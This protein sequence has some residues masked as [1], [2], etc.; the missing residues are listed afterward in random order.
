MSMNN[1]TPDN[2]GKALSKEELLQITED[3]Y[4]QYLI[5]KKARAQTKAYLAL[6]GS[7]ILAILAYTGW[8]FNSATEQ[9]EREKGAIQTTREKIQQI[10][11]DVEKQ[12]VETSKEAESVKN[13]V[14]DANRLAE[15]S[16]VMT[17][18]M[19][20]TAQANLE[21]SQ[22]SQGA[23][24]EQQGKLLN[25]VSEINAAAKK[26]LDEVGTR[27]DAVKTLASTTHDQVTKTEERVNAVL[28]RAG[29]LNS[30]EGNLDK[31]TDKAAR[32]NLIQNRL[33]QGGIVGTVFMRAKQPTTIKMLDP[34]H[35]DEE[36]YDWLITFVRFKLSKKRLTVWGEARR[37]NASEVIPFE[38]ID[39]DTTPSKM[40]RPFYSLKKYGIPFKLQLN[41]AYHTLTTRDFASLRVFGEELPTGDVSS[42]ERYK[43]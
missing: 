31:L 18:A 20:E 33:L 43:D 40:E 12:N 32:L 9:I 30:V 2:K 42:N 23:F 28:A 4:F 39:I 16:T 38:V 1:E 10:A 35:P 14:A 24:F 21:N 8:T 36:K 6:I 7:A 25:T 41:F 34:I 27:L 26:Q 19:L 3:P 37:T 11:A 29:R 15:Q 13:T 5:E 22:K 17:N